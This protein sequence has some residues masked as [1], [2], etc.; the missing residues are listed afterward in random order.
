MK[1]SGGV[2][3]RASLTAFARSRVWNAKRAGFAVV[4]RRRRF[5]LGEGET[6]GICDV[7][8]GAWGVS[9]LGA[10]AGATTGSTLGA[11]AGAT[12]G[13]TLGSDA[14]VVSF[15]SWGA[16]RGLVLCHWLCD[17]AV[18]FWWKTALSAKDTF[19]AGGGFLGG[20]TWASGVS[21]LG[22]V[23]PV[24]VRMS[25]RSLRAVTCVGWRWG[26]GTPYGVA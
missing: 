3:V 26:M 1:E 16:L 19:L 24:P 10:A 4:R 14:G 17:T 12:T 13:S 15:D 23:F 2:S 18:L 5:L 21:L 6:T 11:A 8:V 22:S 9:T 20:S 7:A 25:V